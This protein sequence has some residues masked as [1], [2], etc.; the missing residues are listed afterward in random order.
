MSKTRKNPIVHGEN[1]LV[2]RMKGVECVSLDDYI[3]LQKENEEMK[4]YQ[5]TT[6]GLWATDRPDLIVDKK[7]IMFQLSSNLMCA[8]CHKE[9]MANKHT[10]FCKRCYVDWNNGR[11]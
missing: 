4:H 6:V 1:I 5:D 7:K 2:Y 8:N 11:I 3:E 10:G 9:P